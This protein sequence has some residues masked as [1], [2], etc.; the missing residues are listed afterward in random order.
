MEETQN[1]KIIIA[2]DQNNYKIFLKLVDNH[3]KIRDRYYKAW[4]E[5]HD[6]TT[7]RKRKEPLQYQVI[8]K[9]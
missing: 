1:D 3:Q 9:V 7:S 2:F 4:K 5:S 8:G 6:V